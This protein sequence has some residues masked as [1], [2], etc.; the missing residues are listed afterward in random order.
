MIILA[1]SLN[2]IFAK[3][4]QKEFYFKDS[5]NISS[6]KITFN[7]VQNSY[8]KNYL[9]RIGIFKIEDSSNKKTYILKPES[10]Y[11]PVSDSNTKEA[12]IKYNLFSDLYI[13]LGDKVSDNSFFVRIYFRPFISFIW[14]GCLMIFFGALLNIFVKNYKN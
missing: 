10:R 14:L 5:A 6:Y 4:I 11:Y 13:V 1:I 3:S 8:G 7:E 12:A 2:A 9:T